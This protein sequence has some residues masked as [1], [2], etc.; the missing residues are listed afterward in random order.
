MPTLHIPAETSGRGGEQTAERIRAALATTPIC[1]AGDRAQ[2]AKALLLG[3]M[4]VHLCRGTP[5][6]LRDVPEAAA[7][8]RSLRGASLP[9]SLR[10]CLLWAYPSR[11]ST[12]V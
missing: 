4:A 10:F 11:S 9:W 1:W 5:G 2:C 12:G 7:L 8:A 6:M 3:P